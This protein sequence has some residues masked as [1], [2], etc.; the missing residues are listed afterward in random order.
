MSENFPTANFQYK[1]SLFRDY[2]NDR[3]RL[4]SLCNALLDTNYSDANEVEI[5]TLNGNFFSAL[6][7][8]ISFK[9][10]DQFLILVEHQSTVNNNMPLRCLS[11][12]TELF[13]NLVG[14]KNRL[15]RKAAVRLPAPQFFVFYDGRYPEPLKRQMRLSDAFRGSNSALELVVTSFN[16]NAGINQPLLQKCGYLNDYST[17]IDK[18]RKSC[19]EGL[20]RREAI[21]QAINWCIAHD[22]MKK[23]LVIRKNEVF[24][25]LDLQWNLDDAKAAWQD[26]AREHGRAEGENKLGALISILLN[27]GKTQEIQEASTNPSR[28]QEL[29]QL[30]GIE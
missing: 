25:M 10:G 11:Y 16:I 30:Y 8:D 24:T 21:I 20:T 28:R 2:F 4:L 23:Y 18:V 27:L 14:E 22:V 3:H 17:L 13:N 15:Y 9:I 5:N 6:K 29:Y 1:D 26:E 19:A 7:N 12:V